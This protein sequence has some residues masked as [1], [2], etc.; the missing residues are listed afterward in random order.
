MRIPWE[1]K[2]H[3]DSYARRQGFPSKFYTLHWTSPEGIYYRIFPGPPD[4]DWDDPGRNRG[5]T[6]EIQWKDHP[7]VDDVR[8]FRQSD[9][10]I[11]KRFAEKHYEDL[12]VKDFEFV[13]DPSRYVVEVHGDYLSG[14]IFRKKTPR[15]RFP[16]QVHTIKRQPNLDRLFKEI[17]RFLKGRNLDPNKINSLVYVEQV[18]RGPVTTRVRGRGLSTLKTYAKQKAGEEVE[19]QSAPQDR[20][21]ALE[22]LLKETSRSDTKELAEKALEMMSR[23]QKLDADFLKKIRHQ[24]Y[25]HRMRQEADLFR[26][27]SVLLPIEEFYLRT[28][29]E[30]LMDWGSILKTKRVVDEEELDR[31]DYADMVAMLKRLKAGQRVEIS[32][33]DPMRGGEVTTVRVISH[34]W[35]DLREEYP[36]SFRRPQVL[37]EPKVRGKRKGGMVADYGRQYGVVWQ[38]TMMTQVRPIT[39]IR[40][41]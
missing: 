11:P 38:P 23:R 30:A 37:L 22:L 3:L 26:A 8:Y 41:V 1:Y 36:N 18:G 10:G 40:K 13:P 14:T 39:G 7:E 32:Y 28:A 9:D 12:K 16:E 2:E 31:D 20:K 29:D 34:S 25:Q 17:E 24:L 27:A 19:V 4:Q 21:E 6:L 5:Y 15:D 35:D 33:N